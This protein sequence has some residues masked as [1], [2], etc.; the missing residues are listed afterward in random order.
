MFI[1]IFVDCS[2]CIFKTNIIVKI[3]LILG[4]R[5]ISFYKIPQTSGNVN[6]HN[7]EKL[8]FVETKTISLNIAD[9]IASKQLKSDV[10]RMAISSDFSHRMLKFIKYNIS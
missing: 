5:R 4:T 2:K 10:N 1:L 6:N 8:Y 7:S 9:A 3:F